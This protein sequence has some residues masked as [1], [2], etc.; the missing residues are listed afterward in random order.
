MG[1]PEFR[2]TL[3]IVHR[4]FVLCLRQGQRQGQAHLP[5]VESPDRMKRQPIEAHSK[6]LRPYF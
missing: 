4:S 3:L 5:H 1:H 6:K 2:L